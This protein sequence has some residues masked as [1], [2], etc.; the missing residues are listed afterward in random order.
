MG[1]GQVVCELTLDQNAIKKYR[2][3][4]QE[5]FIFELFMDHNLLITRSLDKED[6]VSEGDDKQELPL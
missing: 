6:I 3:I 1:E 2:E 5:N 4:I